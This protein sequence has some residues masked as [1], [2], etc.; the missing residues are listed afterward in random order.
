MTLF[1]LCT[2][3]CAKEKIAVRLTPTAAE[4]KAAAIPE[5]KEPITM[6]TSAPNRLKILFYPLY[7][8]LSRPFNRPQLFKLLYHESIKNTI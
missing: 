1:I 8:L 6:R 3:L 2:T 4:L 5:L 7:D